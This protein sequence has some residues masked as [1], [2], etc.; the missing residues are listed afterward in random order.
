MRPLHRRA[1]VGGLPGNRYLVWETPGRPP[2]FGGWKRRAIDRH[3][4]VGQL[5]SHAARQ[6]PLDENI[7]FQNQFLPFAGRAKL[8]EDLAPLRTSH[9]RLPGRKRPDELHER[10]AAHEIRAPLGEMEGEPAAPVLG[11][12]ISRADPGLRDERVEIARVVLEA[13]GDIRL[14]RLTEADEIR[15]DAMGD[16]R[17]E[18]GNVSPYVG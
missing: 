2:R 7:V 14:A 3:L 15:R 18:R 16:G 1:D 9:E 5:M 10:E 4:F 8:A 6:H 11:D 13:I 12:E 17:N